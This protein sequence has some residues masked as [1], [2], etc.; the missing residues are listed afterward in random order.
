MLTRQIVCIS[1][2]VLFLGAATALL[3]LAL[4]PRKQGV[5][6]TSKSDVVIFKVAMSSLGVV[7][8]IAGVA[9][10]VLAFVNF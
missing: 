4:K 6:A 10:E 8:L 2:G 5:I 3:G 7:C 1:L 9:L